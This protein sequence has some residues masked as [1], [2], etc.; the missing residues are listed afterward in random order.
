MRELD[1]VS[2]IFHG[3]EDSRG[4]KLYWK[5]EELKEKIKNGVADST[6]ACRAILMFFQ[7]TFCL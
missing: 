5:C 7:G 4:Q 2:R 1:F 6:A 3:S